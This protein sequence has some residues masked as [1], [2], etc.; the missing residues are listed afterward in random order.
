MPL[1]KPVFVDNDKTMKEPPI[2]KT[3]S[4]INAR[5]HAHE[6]TFTTYKKARVLTNPGVAE[7]FLRALDEA[8]H[9]CDFDIWAYVVMPEHCHVLIRPR[10]ETYK[11]SGILSAIKNPASR[12][13]FEACPELQETMSVRS[14]GRLPE[15]RLWLPGGG[16]DR[17]IV[18]SA[19]A[20][21]CIRYIHANPMVRGLT[22]REEDWEWSS[23]RAYNGGDGPIPVD[24]CDWEL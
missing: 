22:V 23:V 13:A 24:L 10:Q 12:A 17:N 21:K 19:T 5:G 16:Y 2:R 1:A 7:G 8:R 6:L 11:M 3:R 9:S 4:S 20:W 14:R 15:H 18:Q